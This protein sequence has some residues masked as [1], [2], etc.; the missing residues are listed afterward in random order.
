MKLLFQASAP[1][2]ADC[3]DVERLIEDG[4]VL[5]RFLGGVDSSST[6]EEASAYVDVD[7]SPRTVGFQG[8]WWYRGEINVTSD[9][10]TLHYRVFNIARRGAWAVPLANRLFIGY[11]ASVQAAVD[12]LARAVEQQLS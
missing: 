11:A 1:V 7:Y 9:P 5:Q 2:N 3:S 12:G 10:T 4:W 6:A 8:H